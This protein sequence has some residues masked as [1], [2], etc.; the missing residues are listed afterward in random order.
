MGY[1]LVTQSGAFRLS[2]LQLNLVGVLTV[3]VV[4]LRRRVA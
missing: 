2:H 3:G 4:A 1:L